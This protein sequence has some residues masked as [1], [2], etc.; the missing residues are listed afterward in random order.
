MESSLKYWLWLSTRAGLSSGKAADLYH[1]FRRSIE[2]VYL[3]QEEHFR[4]FSFSP[5]VLRQLLDKSLQSVEGILTR[6]YQNQIHLLTYQD[7]Q[8]PQKF[9]IMPDPPIVLYLKGNLPPVDEQLSITMVG[10][11]SATPYGCRATTE[12][13]LELSQAGAI[14]VTGMA[15]GIDVSAVE[16]AL[17]AGGPLISVV[18]GGIDRPFPP[19]H[20][21]LYQ[22]VASVGV[23]VSEYPPG[24]P[25]L[26]RH[27]RPRNRI[28]CGFSNGVFLA[29]SKLS[30]G[31]MMTA[32]LAQE[33]QRELF[34]LPG[35]ISSPTS[36]GCHHLIQNHN[37]FLTTCAQDILRYYQRRYPL[38]Y[39]R[40]TNAQQAR[41]EEVP[42]PR[43]REKK[44]SSSRKTTAP[45][46]QA[47]SPQA[48]QAE[49]LP[50]VPLSQQKDRFTEDQITLLLSLD[51]ETKHIDILL[52]LTQIPPKRAI[53][54]LTLLEMDGC[55]QEVS[56][57]NY[58]SLLTLETPLF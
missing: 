27:F 35:D 37:A 19:E 50:F 45:N 17:K 23:M 32:T 15:E 33:Q 5:A 13:A 53:S 56:P 29:E 20:A 28:L 25:H 44:S 8:Y 55:V 47:E 22:D 42:P 12:I 31:S 46:S 30:G 24:T 16:G 39:Y 1:H 2:H 26:G 18:A 7:A 21:P 52:E 43:K 41:V 4:P 58:R 49:S 10:S 57:S 51:R 40:N 9:R 6:C 3:A 14:V 11:R 36:K 34:A 48:T 38:H 54:A